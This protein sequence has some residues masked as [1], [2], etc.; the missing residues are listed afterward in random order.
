MW[1]SCALRV[2]LHAVAV[3]LKWPNPVMELLVGVVF[4][5][6]INARQLKHRQ[7][8]TGP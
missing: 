7:T 8:R 3:Q 1:P 2:G 5:C 6:V 4:S